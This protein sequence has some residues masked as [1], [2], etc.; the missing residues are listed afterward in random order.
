MLKFGNVFHFKMQFVAI[1]IL[2][3]GITQKG[4]AQ[5]FAFQQF[6]AE[7]GLPGSTVYSII[8]DKDQFIWLATDGGICKYDGRSFQPLD[9]ENIQGEIIKLTYDSK[10]RIWMID[11]AQQMSFL[12]NGNVFNFA[13]QLT[14]YPITEILEDKNDAYWFLHPNRASVIL[15]S[16][17]SNAM[18]EHHVYDQ[19]VVGLKAFIPLY[20]NHNIIINRDGVH[21]F[22]DYKWNFERFIGE[23]PR[24]DFPMIAMEYNDSILI[25]SRYRIFSFSIN[26]N[27]IKP[28]FTEINHLLD[29]G[30]NN[31]FLDVD[32]NLWIATRD[33]VIFFQKQ[34]D[35]TLKRIKMLEGYVTQGIFQDV[36]KNIWISTQREGIFKLSST[37]I[38]VYKNEKYGDR[39]AVIHSFSENEII[40]GYN[41]NWVTILD[42][43]LTPVFEKKLSVSNEEIYDINSSPV[44]GNLILTANFGLFDIASDNYSFQQ[45]DPTGSGYKT[46]IASKNNDIWIGTFASLMKMD[47]E[48]KKRVILKKRTYSI[49]EGQNEDLWIGTVEGLYNCK[50]E[51]C[52]N[53]K[54]IQLQQDIRDLQ[55]DEDGILWIATQANGLYLFQNGNI[56]KHLSIENGLSS[57][58][59]QKIILDKNFA[60]VATNNGISKIDRKDFS[61]EVIRR[62]DGLPSNEV[63]YLHQAGT[64]IYA[65]TNKGLAVFDKDFKTYQQPPHLTLTKVQIQNQDTSILPFYQLPHNNNNITFTLTGNTFKNAEEV[66]YQ[67]KMIGLEEDWISTKVNI[68]PY[69]ALP[70]GEFEFVARAKAL[71]SDWTKEQRIKIIIER[72]YWNTWWFFGIVAGVFFIAGAKFLQVVI[73]EIKQRNEIQQNLKESQLTALRAQM[74]PHFIFNSLNSIQDFI[75]QEDKRSANHYLSQ[76]S[77]LMRNI[78][79][80]SDRNKISLKKEIDYLKLYLSL[81]ALR[82]GSSF[83]YVFEVEENINTESIFIPS[84]L[85]QPFVENA[86]KH[87]LMHQNGEK[88]LW[89]RFIREEKYLLCEVEDN[90]VGRAQSKIINLQNQRVY[91]SK[92]MSLTQERIDLLNSADADNLELEIND[93]KNKD[94][95]SAGTKV[96]IRIFEQDEKN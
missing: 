60:W 48:G 36:E 26:D 57:N 78:L 17:S 25:T 54:E 7:D 71:N 81:E 87:G 34:K 29:A 65:A 85:L 41:N 32:Q 55:L 73:G 96:M 6:T 21:H 40:V 53:V 49:C 91:K 63:K 80:A 10:G 90:G 45:I 56:A 35:G 3:F 62:D 92:A 64:K 23:V 38:N 89:V 19:K 82:F 58:N 1:I 84:M 77:K 30:I 33:G 31:L 13:N 61:I 16:D 76:F 28:A 47:S 22:R 43:N 39:V 51:V 14:D 52:E 88:R 67:H 18:P 11:L 74:D 72:A 15:E 2:V 37:Q 86:I 50:N 12:E 79:V 4:E 46:S 83:K 42:E 93:L 75:V 68:A 70:S 24:P 8:Q 9:D 94:G 20:E 95:S 66:L 27:K 44:D 5:G 59:C 69:P